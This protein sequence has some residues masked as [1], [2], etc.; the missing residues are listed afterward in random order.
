LNFCSSVYILV[1]AL[2]ARTNY[3]I[4][5]NNNNNI[6]AIQSDNATY[7]TISFKAV[8]ARIRVQPKEETETNDDCNSR[9]LF[10]LKEARNAVPAAVSFPLENHLPENG[11]QNRP[12]ELLRRIYTPRCNQQE[13]SKN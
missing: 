4:N 5:N 12:A 10:H 13:I 6:H 3:I 1:C 11:V 9:L 2:S 7:R 8:A